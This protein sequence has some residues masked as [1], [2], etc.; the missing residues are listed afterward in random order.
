M[1]VATDPDAFAN[2]VLC[3]RVKYEVTRDKCNYTNEGEIIVWDYEVVD[4]HEVVT[5]WIKNEVPFGRCIH[6]W[7]MPG[8]LSDVP[9]F[10]HHIEIIGD[11]IRMINTVPPHSPEIDY[12]DDVEDVTDELKLLSMVKVDPEKHFVKKPRY[13]SGIYKLLNKLV[14]EKLLDCRYVL[15]LYRSIGIYKRW[16]LHLI[17]SLGILYSLGIVHE[18]IDTGN[19]LFTE[20][21]GRLIIGDVEGRWGQRSAPEIRRGDILDARWM[22]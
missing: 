5:H 8:T 7:N 18:D 13:K 10:E 15:P 16:T 17:S 9:P 4:G 19:L 6:F 21:G 22:E 1:A 3:Q 11:T 14:F 20:K 2:E 12:T